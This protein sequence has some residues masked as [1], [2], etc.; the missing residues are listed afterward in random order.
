MSRPASAFGQFDP[1]S[2][3]VLRTNLEAIAEVEGLKR[4]PGPMTDGMLRMFLA[5]SCL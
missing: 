4:A 2:L 3:Q 1:I 5:A